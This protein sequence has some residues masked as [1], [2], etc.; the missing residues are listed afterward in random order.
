MFLKK[1]KK[2]F[3]SHSEVF[4]NYHIMISNIVSKT[5]APSINTIIASDCGEWRLMNKLVQSLGSNDFSYNFS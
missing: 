5:V 4:Q 1:V 3:S 2:A